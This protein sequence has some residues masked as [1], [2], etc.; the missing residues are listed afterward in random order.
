MDCSLAPEADLLGQD[1]R[2]FTFRTRRGQIYRSLF[3]ID[4]DFIQVLAVRGSGQ[5]LTT[6]EELGL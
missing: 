6:A 4:G 2:Q 1:I 5:N 3:L